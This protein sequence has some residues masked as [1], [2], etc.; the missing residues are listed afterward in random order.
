MAGKSLR[1]KPPAS[2]PRC[3]GCGTSEDELIELVLLAGPGAR[4][5]PLTLLVPTVTRAR[6]CRGCLNTP[7]AE[8]LAGILMS[9][10]THVSPY[11]APRC[12]VFCTETVLSSKLRQFAQWLNPIPNITRC[13]RCN[14]YARIWP[15]KS[16]PETE[17][18]APQTQEIEPEMASS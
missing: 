3:I 16:V 18:M 13:P 14:N 17:E 12:I 8:L 5:G 4:P 6:V 10:D 15:V 11:R 9:P 1:K 7:E 2:P